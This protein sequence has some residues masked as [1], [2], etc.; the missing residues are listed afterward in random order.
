MSLEG[1]REARGVTASVS[2]ST[3][4]EEKMGELAEGEST[5][6]GIDVGGVTIAERGGRLVGAGEEAIAVDKR[7]A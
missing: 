6:I 1:I 5:A 4:V 7:V 3:R 2:V